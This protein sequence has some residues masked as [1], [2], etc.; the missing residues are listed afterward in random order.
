MNYYKP[1][2]ECAPRSELEALQSYRLSR[3]VR[4]VYENVAPYRKKMD[5]A[6]V[7]PEDIK[8]IADL[9]KL[10]F[11]VKQDL[12]DNYPYGMFASPMKDI[13]RIHA[14][15]GTTGKQTVVGYTAHD[16][17]MWAECAARALVSVGGTKDDFIHISYGYGLF[18]GGLGLHYGAEKLGATAIPASAGNSMRQLQLFKDFGSS[19]ICMTPSYA[20]SLIELMKENNISKDE[21][22]LKAGVFGAEPWTEEMRKEIEAGLGIK[23]Y[24]IYGL[25]EIMGPS[26]S[27][28][29]ECQCGM[30]IC[31]DHFIPEIIDPDTL[32]VLPAGQQGE[33]VFTCIT[34]EALPLIRYRTRDI[35][36]L[37]YDKCECGR[38]L[39]RMLKPQGRTDDMLIIRGVNVFP[40]QIESALLSVDSKATNYFLEVDRVNN[41][42]T[43]E[44]QVEMRE[45]MFGDE[46]KTLEAYK[47]KVKAAIDSAIGVGVSVKLVEPKTLARST[48]KAV[49]VNDK[50][51]IKNKFT[52]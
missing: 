37:V 6:G 38:T 36:T 8:S 40:S 52:K 32:E 29:C 43:L 30:H 3:T 2:I 46:I 34:K 22:K 14:S 51:A 23:A 11:T 13:V 35:A 39:V 41:L 9:Q 15:S 24:D 5:E 1:E 49:R 21:F 47:K 33:L 45:D 16:I 4:R 19:I 25:S 31:E 26:V 44:V 17:D 50:R 10:P 7:K 12:R 48:G 42:D 28:E 27:C 20:I 18:T